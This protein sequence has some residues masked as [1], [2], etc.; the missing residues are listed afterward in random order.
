MMYTKYM[1]KTRVVITITNEMHEALTRHAARRGASVA[2]LLR[3]L[4]GEWLEAQGETVD[5]VIAWGG[6]RQG[7]RADG[8]AAPD[9]PDAPD[10]TE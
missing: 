2:G 1:S 10:D 6:P 7:P 5:W 3:S 4:A 9:D 8:S